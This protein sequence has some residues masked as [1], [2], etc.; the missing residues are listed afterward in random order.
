MCWV[1]DG[2]FGARACACNELVRLRVY[3]CVCL[4]SFGCVLA[5]LCVY[6]CLCERVCGF[7][8]LHRIAI[9]LVC[10]GRGAVRAL[11]SRGGDV[12]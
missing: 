5:C 3:S 2:V 4:C 9:P 10:V 1:L 12:R 7:V 8:R 6:A 11:P